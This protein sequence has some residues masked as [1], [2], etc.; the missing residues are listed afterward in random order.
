MNKIE[1]VGEIIPDAKKHRTMSQKAHE[2]LK[3]PAACG[4][5]VELKGLWPEPNWVQVASKLGNE[6]AARMFTI[7][8]NLSKSPRFHN[9][10]NS[11]L[12][13]PMQTEAYIM[14]INAIKTFFD[15]CQ[16]AEMFEAF[17]N[18]FPATING[19]M[20]AKFGLKYDCG[21]YAASRPVRNRVY[22]TMA[23][24]YGPHRLSKLLAALNWP[25][26]VK[27]SEVKL[28]V[29][30]LIDRETRRSF[31]SVGVLRGRRFSQVTSSRFHSYQDAVSWL[32]E[33]II[34]K[35]PVK[36]ETPKNKPYVFKK[37]LAALSDCEPRN[38]IPDILM[39]DFGF[40]GVQFG[41]WLSQQD[42]QRFVDNTYIALMCLSEITEIEKEL[43][44]M[45][46][47][48]IAFGA[49]GKSSA[50]AHFEHEL[51]VINLTKTNGPGSIAHEYCHFFDYI[52]GANDRYRGG[53]F[54][55][56][57]SRHVFSKSSPQ[58]KILNALLDT[59][60]SLKNYSAKSVAL[61]TQSGKKSYWSSKGEMF[62]RA[63][64]S[65]IQDE[66]AIRGYKCSW[67]A[68]GTTIEEFTGANRNL[69]PYPEGNERLISNQAF[70]V[71]F[72]KLSD[73]V[74]MMDQ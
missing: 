1:D 66:I 60:L 59:V 13:A 42:R 44:G 41:N 40:R 8:K 20:S 47:L 55:E 71:F 23:E 72:A 25:W 19:L 62:A 4:N 37:N 69:F 10:K 7:Y 74:F 65:Y 11:A 15:H 63:F 31:W 51:A 29:I 58:L 30:T 22:S 18:E 9:F 45:Q 67:L 49:R 33:D 36:D 52:N 2:E 46:L 27:A 3:L 43:I 61:D 24:N 50:S 17:K 39:I 14:S 57:P 54:S 53:L 48:G 32:K 28:D 35:R 26:D 68:I 70:K 34:S 64:E 16:N 73:I 5:A 6:L 56:N 38:I 12:S 21:E